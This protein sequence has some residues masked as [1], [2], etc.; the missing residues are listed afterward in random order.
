MASAGDPTTLEGPVDW[1]VEGRT[2]P[3]PAA[4]SFDTPGQKEL[5]LSLYAADG[6][7]MLRSEVLRLTVVATGTR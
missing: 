2:L 1:L 5:R 3:D 4:V 7:T 6:S